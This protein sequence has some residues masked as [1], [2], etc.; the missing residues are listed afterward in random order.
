MMF[1]MTVMISCDDVMITILTLLKCC[2]IA[3]YNKA[4]Y[5]S[6]Y[7]ILST[8]YISGQRHLPGNHSNGNQSHDSLDSGNKAQ[9]I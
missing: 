9:L 7:H 5:T 1:L 2:L 4:K 8:F 6:R 3:R